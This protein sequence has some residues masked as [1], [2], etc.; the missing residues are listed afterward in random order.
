MKTE[1]AHNLIAALIGGVLVYAFVGNK[2]QPP[3]RR[4]TTN[5]KEIEKSYIEGYEDAKKD[6][7]I[8]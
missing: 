1:Q 8:K 5:F 4:N 7:G 6:Y 3:P 2:K